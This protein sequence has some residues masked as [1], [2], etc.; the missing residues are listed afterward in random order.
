M[1][2]KSLRH[3][4]HYVVLLVL[5]VASLI[6][7]FIIGRNAASHVIVLASISIAVAYFIWGVVHSALEDEFHA[8]IIFEY[9]LFA[10]L[11]FALVLGVLY[12]L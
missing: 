10:S 12:Y 5:M 4:Y 6:A 1:K 2:N 11:G 8:E 3:V 9:F 7:T